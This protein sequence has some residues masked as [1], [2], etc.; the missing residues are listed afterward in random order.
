MCVRLI[1]SERYSWLYLYFSEVSEKYQL[2]RDKFLHRILDVVHY[3]FR[4]F[5]DSARGIG[6]T[7][8]WCLEITIIWA[9]CC[10]HYENK[11]RNVCTSINT[12]HLAPSVKRKAK[13]DCDFLMVVCIEGISWW[14]SLKTQPEHNCLAGRVKG[15]DWNL[16][17]NSFSELEA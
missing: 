8:E 11:I 13:K 15:G 2:G 16:N 10:P 3:L 4:L 6:R 17:Q 7:H 1:W 12:C 5:C 9:D 14:S